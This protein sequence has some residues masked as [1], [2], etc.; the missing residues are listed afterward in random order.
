MLVFNVVL[1]AVLIESPTARYYLLQRM[2]S[3]RKLLNNELSVFEP[4]QIM[5]LSVGTSILAYQVFLFLFCGKDSL[6]KRIKLST[7]RLIRRIP[8][9]ST[10]IKKELEKAKRGLRKEFLKSNQTVKPVC[11][12]PSK[13]LSRGEVIS[14]LEEINKALPGLDWRGGKVS[15][16]AYNCS[17]EITDL[18]SEVYAKYSW[19]NPMHAS[20]FPEI[21]KM[22]AEVVSF[23]VNLFNGGPEACGTVTS[24]GTESILLAMR[25]Y[26]GLAYSRGI[27][28]PEIIGSTA[29]HAAFM[30]AAD[31]FCMKFVAVSCDPLTRKVNLN[32]M[33]KAI[34]SRTIVLIGNAPQ[35]PYGVIDPIQDIAKIALKYKLGVHVDSCLG[36]FILPFMDKAG[37]PIEPFDF[38]VK[39]VTSIS[40]DTHKYGYSPKGSSVIMYSNNELRRHQFFVATD[41]E[42]GIYPSPTIAGSRPGGIVAA[43]WATMMF[44]GMDGYVESTRKVVETTRWLAKEIHQIPGLYIV[45]EPL[46]CALGFNSKQFDIYRLNSAMSKKGWELNPLQFPP[47]LHISVTLLHTGEMA[48]VLVS[49]IKSC[50]DEILR[51]PDDK[52]SSSAAFYGTSQTVSD[53]SIVSEVASFFME[54]YYTTDS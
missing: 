30:K 1:I 14:Y 54:V 32:K 35:Y 10:K 9:I 27:E 4:W 23:C 33:K 20:V 45:G 5:A 19:T 43:T 22:E 42:M 7:L 49:D 12:L 36:G 17:K 34:T 13:G 29:T 41:P 11:V 52:L 31:Y 18:T 6:K 8:V 16:C 51:N 39:G 46:S 50:V 37:F 40:A 28:Y 47:G 24:G 44:M 15:G 48:T 2:D 26:R 38:R 53:R 3:I 25:A 21:R